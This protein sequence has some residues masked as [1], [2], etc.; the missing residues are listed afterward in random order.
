MNRQFELR[1]KSLPIY[2]A[3]FKKCKPCFR[4]NLGCVPIKGVY[5][6]IENQKPI[7]IGRTN[8]MAQRLLEHSR[9]SSNHY[10]ACFAFKLA[11]SE[12]IK[13]GINILASRKI[14]QTDIKFKA[15]FDEVKNRVS[16][17]AIKYV[18]INDPVDQA[19]F[20]VY[21]SEVFKT[22]MNDFENH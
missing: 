22:P 9:K 21:A 14:L 18:E 8:R 6:F 12:A 7:Y 1:I 15:L 16:K 20:E 11:K 5:M 19:L 4:D 2:L 10:H 17:M 3:A 13:C